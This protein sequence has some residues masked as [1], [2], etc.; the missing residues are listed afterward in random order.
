LLQAKHR[1]FLASRKL[2]GEIPQLMM[3]QEKEIENSRLAPKSILLVED[4][5]GDSLR[6]LRSM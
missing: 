3:E 1:D 6:E 5:L 4:N 2:W